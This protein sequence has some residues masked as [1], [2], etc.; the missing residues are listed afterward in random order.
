MTDTVPSLRERNRQLVRDVVLDAAERL[1][2]RD[3]AGDFSMRALA[4]EAGVGFATPFNHFGSKNAIMQ[5]LSARIID[6]MSDRFRTDAPS[7]NAIDRVLAMAQIAVTLLLEQPK[8]YRTVVGS[9]SAPN[10]G[11]SAVHKRSRALWAE[12]LGKFDGI[13]PSSRS[14]A[15]A[16]L[17]EQIAFTIRGCLSFWIA[18]E[19]DDAELHRKVCGAISTV[20]LGFAGPAHRSALQDTIRA[21][22]QNR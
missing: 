21:A 8:V 22:G 9:L 17:A 2:A 15:E 20:L 16:S 5:A 11:T 14:T 4:L 7:G 12:A 6:R 19:I 1:L 13:A 10:T 18:G 3:D